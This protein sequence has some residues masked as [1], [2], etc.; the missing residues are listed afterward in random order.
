VYVLD[1]ENLVKTYKRAA[2]DGGAGAADVHA[3]NGVSFKVEAGG[4]LAIMGASGSGKS[5]LLHM[6]GGLDTPTSG[7]VKIEGEDLTTLRDAKLSRLRLR[8]VGF[9]FQFFNLLPT[10]TARENVSLPLTLS[11]QNPRA[12]RDK[13]DS[14][15][16]LVGLADRAGHM[17]DQL[18][19][20]EQQRVA[21]AR[22]LVMDPPILLADEPTGNLDSEN[23]RAVYDLLRRLVETPGRGVSTARTVV[24]ATHDPIGASHAGRI[25][26][27]KDGR[28]VGE[29]K[30]Q[31]KFNAASVALR[32]QKLAEG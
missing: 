21:I 8:K 6:L 15:L 3:L 22:A 19:G 24:L 10:L 12:F 7:A 20:G 26:F 18:S 2:G 27:L 1:V 17:P 11:G 32:Y 31:R 13:I 25:L 28:I 9:V 23:S 16:D 30:A 14:L 5:T 29:M 4:F